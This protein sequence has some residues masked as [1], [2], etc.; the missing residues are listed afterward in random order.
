MEAE[1]SYGTGMG[2]SSAKARYSYA[3]TN[4]ERIKSNYKPVKILGIFKRK[5]SEMDL[6]KIRECSDLLRPLS[7]EESV[8]KEMLNSADANN[9][10]FAKI[11]RLEEDI[12][13]Y[14]SEFSN[15]EDNEYKF[16]RPPKVIK[17]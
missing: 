13:A 14:I 5:M 11:T 2:F 6:K 4:F 17:L 9:S 8:K 15:S 16:N 7:L 12:Q 10:L 3:E 1:K